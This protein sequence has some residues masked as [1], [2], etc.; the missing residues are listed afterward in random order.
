MQGI[1]AGFNG[2]NSFARNNVGAA[3]QRYKVYSDALG[4]SDPFMRSVTGSEACSLCQEGLSRKLARPRLEMFF[5]LRNISDVIY[6]IEK[7]GVKPCFDPKEAPEATGIDPKF[8]CTI[9][10]KNSGMAV[11]DAGEEEEEI[12]FLPSLHSQ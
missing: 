8:E 10:Q 7:K 1:Q 5:I 9:G 3:T 4:A 12:G 6:H 11:S 2:A